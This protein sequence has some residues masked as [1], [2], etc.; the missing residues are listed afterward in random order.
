MSIDNN[1][2]CYG[3]DVS[4]NHDTSVVSFKFLDTDK[5]IHLDELE[6][7]ILANYILDQYSST[8]SG[9]AN[10]EVINYISGRI[11]SLEGCLSSQISKL[12]KPDKLDLDKEICE[13][14]KIVTDEDRQRL[15]DVLPHA[16]ASIM[17][18]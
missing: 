5:V 9:A 13:L 17:D 3:L 8:P 4:K 10:M 18:I 14:G 2:L 16:R 11:S 12:A 7:S 1:E 6:L 15:D